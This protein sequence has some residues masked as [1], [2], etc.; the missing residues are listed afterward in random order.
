MKNFR[1]RR[2][3]SKKKLTWGKK[4]SLTPSPCSP[5]PSPLHALDSARQASDAF[6]PIILAVVP[7]KRCLDIGPLGVCIV[8]V[9]EHR[10]SPVVVNVDFS[11]SRSRLLQVFPS[12]FV[13]V[14][15]SSDVDRRSR[16]RQNVDRRSGDSSSGRDRGDGGDGDR[17]GQRRRRSEESLSFLSVVLQA[18]SGPGR[19]A[20]PARGR[21]RAPFPRA[22]GKEK[23]KRVE[24]EENRERRL[25]ERGLLFFF[26]LSSPWC[27]VP[28]STL[29]S[30]SSLKKTPF[31]TFST[32]SRPTPR[33]SWSSQ[34]PPAS[35]KM[36]PSELC[37]P[38]DPGYASSSPP[39]RGR[40]GR[41]K[42]MAST[43]LSS[44]N[45][46]SRR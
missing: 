38:P 27:F 3:R 8:V 18:A 36:P 37:T 16:Q 24:T 33:S 11:P 6:R 41:G 46:D 21:R 40:G 34:A 32:R 42:S 13:Y 25:N 23:K 39:P 10:S 26:S 22:D 1:R 2:W 43:T 7:A 29:T 31:S 4:I 30:S 14:D 17:C 20:R 12:H 9:V 19:R 15:A 5:L 35:G 45:K 28:L 44:P